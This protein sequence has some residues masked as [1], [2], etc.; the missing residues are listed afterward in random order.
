MKAV[1]PYLQTD[2]TLD[3]MKTFRLRFSRDANYAL[4]K[5]LLEVDN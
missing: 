3:I 4:H 1:T 5:I 2:G